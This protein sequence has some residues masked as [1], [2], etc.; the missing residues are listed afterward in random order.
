MRQYIFGTGLLS[1]ITGGVT[2]LRALRNDEP[3]T[4]RVALAWL[5]W[6]ITLALAIGSV[7]DT[8]R[9]RRG[10]V[11]AGDSPVSKKQQKLLK[12]RLAR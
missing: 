6:G 1:A 11:I 7:V 3:F 12:K 5:S 9:A 2:L 8:R 10:K 4:W